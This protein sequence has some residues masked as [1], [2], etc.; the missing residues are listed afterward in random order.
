MGFSQETIDILWGIR[1]NNNRSWFNEHREQYKRFVHDPM[2]EV[3]E[4]VFNRIRAFDKDFADRPKVSRAN[5]DT[6]FSKN[7][8]PYKETKWVMFREDQSS[9]IEHDSPNYYF[10]VSPDAYAFGLGYW[11]QAKG[12]AALRA[13]FDANPAEAS[14]I[15]RTVDDLGFFNVEGEV[16]KRA[17]SK[18]QDA[19]S[20]WYNMKSITLAKSA[21]HDEILFDQERLISFIAEKFLSVYFVYSYF[22]RISRTF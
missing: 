15:V 3:S 22:L 4:E 5:R 14:S 9:G 10:E 12:M 21:P 18:H 8:D 2:V 13:A 19:C 6:R 11:P 20:K 1:F 7:K 16:Y 17:K